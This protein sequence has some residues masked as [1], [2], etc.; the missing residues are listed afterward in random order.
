MPRCHGGQSDDRQVLA[1][2]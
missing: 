2:N 1:R